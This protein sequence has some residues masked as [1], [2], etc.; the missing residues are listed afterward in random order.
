[1]LFRLIAVSLVMI[2]CASEV[3]GAKFNCTATGV[4]IY[5]CIWKP[6]NDNIWMEFS[7]QMNI[8]NMSAVTSMLKKLKTDGCIKNSTMKDV[9]AWIK[10]QTPPN[11]LRAI[12][13]SLTEEQKTTIVT[14][15]NNMNDP[16]N[17]PKVSAIYDIVNKKKENL[18]KA[19]D[20]K[21]TKCVEITVTQTKTFTE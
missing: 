11:P 1:M 8:Y 10:I 14:N 3:L 7:G 19:N 13:N 2:G 4:N 21:V 5:D 12:Y 20:K 15:L 16:E 17:W 18:S 6:E 9:Q